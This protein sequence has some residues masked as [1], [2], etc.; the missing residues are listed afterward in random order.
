MW[1]LRIIFGQ[2]W[3]KIMLAD[4]PQLLPIRLFDTVHVSEMERLADTVHSKRSVEGAKSPGAQ[5][6]HLRCDDRGPVPSTK[7]SG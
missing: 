7:K 3:S 2:Q 5:F 1:C 6:G 4:K